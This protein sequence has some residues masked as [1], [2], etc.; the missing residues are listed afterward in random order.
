MQTNAVLHDS[1]H[2]NSIG[3]KYWIEKYFSIRYECF[4]GKINFGME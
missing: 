3:T 1:Q 4:I 2:V